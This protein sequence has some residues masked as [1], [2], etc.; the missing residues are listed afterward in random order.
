MFM[1]Y[2]V[3]EEKKF[4][5][6]TSS[7]GTGETA[8]SPLGIIYAEPVYSAVGSTP[9]NSVSINSNQGDNYVSASV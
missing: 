2:T 4:P 6:A 7:H 1:T 9:N 8:K 5:Q 3:E